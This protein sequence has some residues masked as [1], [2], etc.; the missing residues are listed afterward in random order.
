MLHIDVMHTMDLGI[1]E[2]V[3]ANTLFTIV[4]QDMPGRGPAAKEQCFN[5]IWVKIQEA[6]SRLGLE[7]KLSK[8]TLQNIVTDVE[9]PFVDYPKL[10]RVKAAECKRL[11]RAVACVLV[12]HTS[13]G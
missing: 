9:S 3:V 13:L 1:T 2:H 10:K 12:E 8:L 5:Q 11:F 4:Y 7:Y 6:Y